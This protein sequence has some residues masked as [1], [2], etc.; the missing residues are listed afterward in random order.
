MTSIILV[1]LFLL[2][3][4]SFYFIALLN[5]KLTKFNNMEQKQ[6]QILAEIEDSFSAY[7]AEIKDE[8]DRLLRELNHTDRVVA[9]TTEQVEE[10]ED[11]IETTP[12]F[13]VPK[14]FVSK[15]LAA[16]SYLKTASVIEKKEPVT[17]KE[18]VFFYADEG[19]SVDEIAQKLQIGKTE[20]ELFLKFKH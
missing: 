6:E 5:A 15:Q 19:K 1:I 20:V 18:K 14:A 11:T 12:V 9:A 7:I 8:N 2:Q 4:I 13:E 17:I 3:L 10:K 16:N